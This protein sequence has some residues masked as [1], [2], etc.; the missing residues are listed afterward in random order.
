ML[1]Q[2]KSAKHLNNK[3][4]LE[5][6]ANKYFLGDNMTQAEEMLKYMEMIKKKIREED[7]D[8]SSKRG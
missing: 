5:Y 3:E 4:C 2:I 7:R 1:D 6:L 8:R